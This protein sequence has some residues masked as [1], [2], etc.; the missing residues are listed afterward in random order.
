MRIEA[1]G[2]GKKAG[3]K[4]LL[5]GVSLDIPAGAVS[6]II[7]PNG[8]GKT[9]LLRILGM[10]DKPS[11]GRMVYD[12]RPS[13]GLNA[14]EKTA[15]RRRLGFVFQHPLLLNGTALGNMR[16]ALALRRRP[17][18][19][20]RVEAA[21]GAVGLAVRKDLDVRL[22]SGGEKQRLQ[23]ARALLLEPEVLLAD[24]PTSNLDPLSARSIEDQLLA[25]AR[26]GKTII[27]TTHNIAQARLLGG[28][29]FFLKD[30]EIVQSG[31]PGQVLQ[32]PATLDVA[33][34]APVTNV[35]NGRLVRAGEDACLEVGGMAIH[36]VSALE[37]GPATAVLRPEDILLSREPF[38][39]SARNVLSGRVEAVDDLGLIVLVRVRCGELLIGAAITRTSLQELGLGPGQAAVL[40]FKAS[41]V[42]VF[43]AD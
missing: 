34:F 16:H 36:V 20:A 11:S 2:I 30:G 29:L 3:R 28:R 24:E 23:L 4:A 1:R 10:L 22:L 31:T 35:L 21:L 7:G 32:N 13:G 26:A 12:G 15:L 38:R 43:P 14:R 18:D 8:A 33:H 39:S 5:R 42:L 40:T 41:A 25:L 19:G 17:F 27:L 9:T 6:V 37:P